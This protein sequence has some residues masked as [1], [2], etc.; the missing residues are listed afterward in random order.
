MNKF[1]RG[2]LLGAMVAI[3]TIVGWVKGN[4]A[5]QKLVYRWRTSYEE[6]RQLAKKRMA[7]RR[8]QVVLDDV[9]WASF[10]NS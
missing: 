3:A 10:H 7:Q 4:D 1:Y 2:F 9:E 6:K 5:K 8:G